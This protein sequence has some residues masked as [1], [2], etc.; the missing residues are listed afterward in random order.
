MYLF[1]KKHEWYFIINLKLYIVFITNM[2]SSNKIF[3]F[4]AYC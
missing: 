2:K 3:M 4:L 1:F